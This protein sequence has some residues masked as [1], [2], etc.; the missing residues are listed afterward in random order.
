ML[1]AERLIVK[2]VFMSESR[3]GWSA[4]KSGTL[5]HA[6]QNLLTALDSYGEKTLVSLSLFKE[7]GPDIA[8]Y[9]SRRASAF[10][11]QNR[12][13]FESGPI[14]EARKIMGNNFLGLKEAV[15]YH[16]LDPDSIS[17]RKWMRRMANVTFDINLLETCRESHILALVPHRSVHDLI[18]RFT[19]TPPIRNQKVLNLVENFDDSSFAQDQGIS[20]GWW[21]V[22]RDIIPN[23]EYRTRTDQETLLGKS[24]QFVATNVATY[25]AT[26]HFM[27]TGERLFPNKMSR[28]RD[29]DIA[30]GIWFGNFD[31]NGFRIDRFKDMDLSSALGIAT[32][33]RP[34]APDS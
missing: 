31:D 2:E 19:D 14:Q 24:Q 25:I 18:D 11:S 10:L 20:D 15:L 6:L 12:G 30:S 1:V 8:A 7:L 28:A 13:D 23:S 22:S 26:C 16:G 32:M 29:L 9:A 4:Q 21:L 27:K 33:Q 3:T 17:T 5:V 34:H